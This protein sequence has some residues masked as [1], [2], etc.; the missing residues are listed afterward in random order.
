MLIGMPGRIVNVGSLNVDHVYRVPTIVRAGE[1]LGSSGLERFAGGK[2]LNQSVAAARAGGAVSHVGCIG[3]DGRW[4][5]EALAGE[6]VEVAA[7]AEVEGPTGHAL[8]QVD[9]AGENAIVIH[10]GANAAIDRADVTAA[11]EA[12]GPG[13]WLLAQNEVPG[14]TDA[15]VSAAELGLSVCVNPAPMTPAVAGWPLDRVDLLVVNRGEGRALTGLDDPEAIA[16]ALADRTGGEVVVTCGEAGGWWRRGSSSQSYA[17][18]AVSAVDTTAAGDTFV[19]YF[20]AGRAEG[21]GVPEG[22]RRAARASGV[23]VTRPGAMPAIPHAREVE[24]G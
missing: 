15:I 9:D 21:R 12:F 5:R 18:A 19:G 2:G 6:G 22:L 3:A 7:V 10:P 1:T 13:D 16:E 4:L 8:I 17:A 23:C 14:V 24:A 20:L 11:L